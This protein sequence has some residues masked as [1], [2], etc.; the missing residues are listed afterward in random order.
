MTGFLPVWTTNDEEDKH[1]EKMGNKVTRES[2][3][4]F[5]DTMPFCMENNEKNM[6]LQVLHEAMQTGLSLSAIV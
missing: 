2:F 4:L 1:E 5:Y 3:V 6:K